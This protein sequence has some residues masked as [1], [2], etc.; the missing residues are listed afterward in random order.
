MTSSL[1]LIIIWTLCMIEYATD[2]MKNNIQMLWS[3]VGPVVLRQRANMSA[4]SIKK[5]VLAM[6][7]ILHEL[8]C[9]VESLSDVSKNLVTLIVKIYHHLLMYLHLTNHRTAPHPITL[10]VHCHLFVAFCKHLCNQV[11]ILCVYS[12]LVS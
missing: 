11:I 3:I 9:D 4:E 5:A 6:I 12:L 10:L 2:V 1:Q 7:S 8:D